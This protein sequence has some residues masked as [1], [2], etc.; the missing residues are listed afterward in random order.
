MVLVIRLSNEETN[1]LLKLIT[2]NQ[3]SMQYNNWFMWIIIC[4][5]LF[6]IFLK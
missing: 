6:A 2:R 4:G 1:E 3:A 5:L